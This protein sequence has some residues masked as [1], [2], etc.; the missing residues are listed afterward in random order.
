MIVES[1]AKLAVSGVGELEPLDR[2][3]IYVLNEDE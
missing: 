1:K 3:Y 2:C